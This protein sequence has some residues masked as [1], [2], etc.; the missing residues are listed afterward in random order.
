MEPRRGTGIL[1]RKKELGALPRWGTWF[2]LE[3]GTE[4]IYSEIG[5]NMKLWKHPYMIILGTWKKLGKNI[6]LGTKT[7]MSELEFNFK[8]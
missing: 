6:E 7:Q 1:G 8:L 5:T 4:N 2:Y 3:L